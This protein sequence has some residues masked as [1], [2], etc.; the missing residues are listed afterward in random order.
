MEATLEILEPGVSNHS[1]LKLSIGFVR[2]IVKHQFKYFNCVAHMDNFIPTIANVWNVPLRGGAMYVVWKKLQQLQLAIRRLAKPISGIKVKVEE[3]RAALTAA[4]HNLLQDR[5]NVAL[6]E[7]VKECTDDVLQWNALEEQVLKQKSRVEWLRLGDGNN[8][9]FHASLKA[10][11]KH[12]GIHMLQK[13]DG[14]TATTQHE[15]EEEI[16]QFYG[17]LVGTS[18]RSMAGID[19]VAM[20]KGRQLTIAEGA[21]LVAPVTESEI[22]TALKGIGDLKAPGVDNYGAHFFKFAWSVVK[23]DV[24]AAVMEFFEKGKMY[25]AVNSTLV[26]LIPK[27][28]GC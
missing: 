27:T 6:I 14:S 11:H 23:K 1:L 4:Q 20:R 8:A 5:M 3:V 18:S 16:L 7:N 28:T 22:Y 13:S 9:Y 17:G 10:K 19:I 24:V 25:K 2:K 15:L 26:T 12:Y 21:S